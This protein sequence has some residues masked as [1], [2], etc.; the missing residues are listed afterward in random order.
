MTLPATE[1]SPP[2]PDVLVVPLG[3]PLQW[4]LL[5]WRDLLRCGCWSLA[6]GALLA[7]FGLALMATAYQHFWLLAGAFSGFLVVAPVLATSIYAMSRA[8][9]HDGRIGWPLLRDTWLSWQQSRFMESGGYWCMVRFGLLLALA[10]T[11]WVVTSAA[12]ITLL[13]P[14]PINAPLDFLRHVVLSRE[15]YLFEAWLAMG[16]ILAAPIFASS[17]VSMPLLLD[18]R[19][20]LLM[21]VLT[22]WRVVLANPGPMA[23]WAAL[24][25]LLVLLSFATAMLGLIL[26][27]PLL[28]HASWHAYRAL[29]DAS[30]LP[31][32]PRAH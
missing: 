24:I 3:A 2:Q 15:N 12:L 21:A 8:V 5:G 19:S 7:A 10:G 1:I 29:V 17:I 9:E 11:G 28:G 16:G 13:A 30:A 6:H 18:R 31:E 14:A 4:L 20:N 23:L 22:S 27:I 25:M 32:R 26:L